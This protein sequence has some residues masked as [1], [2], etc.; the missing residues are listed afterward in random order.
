[1]TKFWQLNEDPFY[2][3]DG[4]LIDEDA[5]WQ[6]INTEP[7]GIIVDGWVRQSVAEKQQSKEEW[8]PHATINS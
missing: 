1:M 4:V 2:D 5:S 8:S 6:D 3:D 7:L